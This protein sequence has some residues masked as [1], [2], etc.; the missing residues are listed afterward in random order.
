HLLAYPA[1]GTFIRGAETGRVYRVA[2]GAPLYISDWAPFGGSQP[3][4][5]VSQWSIDNGARGRLLACQA[6]GTF[7]R[8]AETGRLYRVPGG[9]PLY[10]SDWAPFGGSQPNVA[11]SQWSIDNG[12]LGHLLAYTADG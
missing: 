5:A 2:G 6:D 12:A 3:N 11:V 10:I 7:I 8:G 1:D 4:V 9:A